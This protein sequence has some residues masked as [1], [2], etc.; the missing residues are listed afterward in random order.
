VGPVCWS[1][2]DRP[3]RG[4]PRTRAAAISRRGAVGTRNEVTI[5]GTSPAAGLSA[6]LQ[7]DLAPLV[8]VDLTLA[9]RNLIDRSQLM[10][11]V[12]G[13]LSG[14]ACHHGRHR[15]GTRGRTSSG[16]AVLN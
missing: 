15:T 4:R 5:A 14:R 11:R 16:R 1:R 2:S 12:A 3:V 6:G 10:R 8:H 7:D 9:D 13:W